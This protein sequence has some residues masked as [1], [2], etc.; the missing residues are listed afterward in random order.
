MNI[1]LK[2]TELEEH[3]QTIDGHYIYIYISL[4]TYASS[5]WSAILDPKWENVNNITVIQYKTV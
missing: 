5:G 1:Q 2:K 3:T 4:Q